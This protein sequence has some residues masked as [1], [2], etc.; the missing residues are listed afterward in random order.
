MASPTRPPPIRR[1]GHRGPPAACNQARRRIRG[2]H[3]TL[4][5]LPGSLH[6]RCGHGPPEPPTEA[7]APRSFLSIRDQ[8]HWTA[9][10]GQSHRLPRASAGRHSCRPSTGSLHVRACGLVSA[11]S[12]PP[13][14]ETPWASTSELQRPKLRKDSHLLTG[15][16]AWRTTRRQ[17]PE[18][19]R[20]RER[21]G[22]RIPSTALSEPGG[23]NRF[24]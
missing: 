24:R 21:V 11:P 23:G 6:Q 19:R 9:S 8:G 1:P 5:G 22:R 18:G 14:T 3:G 16:A 7:P 15:K 13:V 10:A 17:R 4:R 20:L 12:R 2:M